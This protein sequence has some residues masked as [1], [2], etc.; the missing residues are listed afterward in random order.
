MFSVSRSLSIP[1]IE[2][3][4]A[5]IVA[6]TDS[7]IRMPLQPRHRGAGGEAS[8]IQ[9]LLTW[10][11]TRP[12]CALQFW[13]DG[14]GA[15]LDHAKLMSEPHGIVACLLADRFIDNSGAQLG[16]D[17]FK[18]RTISR[19]EE[20][21]GATPEAHL[22]GP[23][24]STLCSDDDGL[25]APHSFYSAHPS[26]DNALR[27][28]VGHRAVID[29]IL[30]K[31]VPT[32]GSHARA[33][34]QSFATDEVDDLAAMLYEIFRNTDDHALHEIDGRRVI[35]SVR[36]IYAQH[37]PIAPSKLAEFAG[38]FAPFAKFCKGLPV[39][40]DADTR[41]GQQTNLLEISTFDAGPGFAETIRR[42][43]TAHMAPDEEIDAVQTCFRKN[44]TSKDQSG[45]GQGLFRVLRLLRKK[46]GFLRLRTGRLSL[47]M[48]L[49]RSNWNGADGS[50]PELQV[51]RES[52]DLALVRGSVL[53]LFVPL[54]VK[55]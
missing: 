43:P 33:S 20:L 4:A 36:G 7:C 1:D 49:S 35:K 29:S 8:Y 15:A 23:A 37:I 12:H 44:V 47:W 50:I 18:E 11:A 51:W 45:F 41:A 39:F 3:M 26:G 14:A 5:T 32:Y 55:R 54:R 10:A 42:K 34:L 16:A 27:G 13:K 30:K 53:S 6:S 31:T 21:Y 38:D 40:D 46:K 19:F 52:G 48:D 2:K 28:P 22:K 24:W 17:Q 25:S 9:L